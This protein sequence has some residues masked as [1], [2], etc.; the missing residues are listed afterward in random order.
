MVEKML[1]S[2][3]LLIVLLLLG[4]C[5][6]F[7][8]RLVSFPTPSKARRIYDLHGRT[9]IYHGVNLSNYSKHSAPPPDSTS[10][11]LAGHPWHGEKEADDLKSWGFNL[12]RYLIFWEAVEPTPGNYD[13][14]YIDSAIANI[15]MLGDRGIDV[16]VDL[17]QDLFAQ[18]FHGNG[19]PEWAIRDDG[20][21]FEKQQ[22]WALNYLQPAVQASFKNLWS[23]KDNLLD[24]NIKMVEHVLLKVKQVPNVIGVDVFNEP[25]PDG[26]PLT[27]ERKSLSN[28]YKRLWDM[29]QNHTNGYPFLAFEPWMSTSAGYPTNIRLKNDSPGFLYMPHYYDFFC[30]QNKPYKWFNRQVLKRSMNIRSYEAQEFK[31]PVI[32]GEFG[33]P[34]G[35]KNYL[36]AL[37]DFFELADKHRIGWAYWS[38]DKIIHNDRGFLNEDG[39]PADN[40]FLSK[41]VRIYPQFIQGRNE[42]YQFVNDVF[43]MTWDYNPSD[44]TAP[45]SAPTQ[46]Y[47]PSSWDVIIETDNTF[48]KN[49]NKILVE[50]S[51]NSNT[52]KIIITVVNRNGFPQ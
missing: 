18:K 47:V 11:G 48:S 3:L 37:D 6:T 46:I 36:K 32:I 43:T 52:N 29:W 2:A 12:V 38:Y 33:F 20:K 22:P 9:V 19:C 24:Y 8:R 5:C 21:K 13:D 23:N 15:R 4:G 41:L 10:R 45:I 40:K 49:D 16:I 39:T 25:W 28:Y 14:A 50:H 27:F 30:E 42:K 7:T 44:Y 1:V 34:T 17:H 35:A 51:M 26:W 31:C